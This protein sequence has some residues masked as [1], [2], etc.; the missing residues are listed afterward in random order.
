MQ[1]SL[2][3]YRQLLQQYLAP[4]RQAVA[5]MATLLIVSIVMQLLVPQV[6]RSF[7]NGTQAGIGEQALIQTALLFIGISAFHQALRVLAVY[8]SERVAWRATNALRLDLTAHL[9][10]LDLDFHQ[11][12][13]PGE[14]I[15]RVDGD[16]NALAGFFSAIVIQLMGNILLLLGIVLALAWVNLWLGVAFAALAL[17]GSVLLGWIRR[18]GNRYWQASRQHSAT[19]Y[20]LLGELIAATED[21]RSSGAVTYAMR[22]FTSQLRAWL[23]VARRADFWSSA[24]WMAAM[25]LF[26]ASDALAYG[27]GGTLYLGGTISLGTVYMIIAYTAM[28]AAPIETIRTQLQDLQQA[29]AAI[30]RIQALLAIQPKLTDGTIPLPPGALAVEFNHVGFTYGDEPI[31]HD[32]TFTL[33]AGRV[34][35]LLGRTGSG[36]TT[37]AR[38]FFRLVDPQVGEICAGGV[39]LRQAQISS[40]RGR[41]GFVTQDVQIFEAS[42]RDNITCF[43]PNVS[44]AQLTALIEMLGLSAW[45]AR[46]PNGLDTPIST[47]NLSAGEA[48][49]IALAR[50]FLKDPGLI[51]LD[52]A[53][54]RLDPATEALLEQA[55]DRLLE[56]R[57]ALIIAHRLATL[58]RAT[59]I[60][61]LDKGRMVEHGPRQQLLAD[62]TSH[63]ARLRYAGEG[64]LLG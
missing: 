46:L 21:I 35:G 38:L 55:L 56:G 17:V 48:Q 60:L 22:R 4:Q 31:L 58:D 32:I 8:W 39:D 6:A 2:A 41:V 49:L 54:S 15:E 34:L 28:L 47:T 7:I 18:F 14:L 53:S 16:I 19:F 61:V 3:T 23:P 51:I 37:L 44:D 29:D 40:V 12:H 9:L 1:I 63:F 64:E 62:P 24:I 27:I 25:I 52:E 57:T 10:R 26:A 20:G 43:A 11:R 45:L 59:D 50:V 33:G 36:K 13:S 30:T 5:L 42:L